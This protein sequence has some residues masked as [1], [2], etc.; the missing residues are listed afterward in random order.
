MDAQS[1]RQL[2]A[3]FGVLAF[4]GTAACLFAAAVA[5][6]GSLLI[7]ESRL[8][9]WS[10]AMASWVFGGRGAGVK[11][12]VAAGILLL[13]YSTV[14]VGVSLASSE[15]VLPPGGEKYFCEIDCHLAYSVTSVVSAREIHGTQARGT[16]FILTLRTHFDENTISSHRGNGPL[17]PSPKQLT[18][19][20]ASG[21]HFSISAAGQEALESSGV[22]GTNI[23]TPLRPG[24]SFTTNFVFDLPGSVQNAKL[25][26]E[27]PGSPCWISTVV[28][29]DEDSILHKKTLLA[30]P[31]PKTP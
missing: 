25:L 22:A 19:L 23:L 16:F 3:V 24:E 10:S 14:L 17:E 15:N 26:L 29:G 4:L 30:L 8:S 6:F 7:G 12:L 20:D 28:I 11:I 13:G 1:T 18:L 21:N 27:T 2:M 5:F 31:A 9:N